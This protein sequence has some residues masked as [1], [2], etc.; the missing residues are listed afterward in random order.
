MQRRTVLL[1]AALAVGLTAYAYLFER[2]QPFWN[3][4]VGQTFPRLELTDIDA[5]ELRVPPAF[6]GAP[7]VRET[8]RL[9]RKREGEEQGWWLEGPP[10]PAHLPRVESI[11]FALVELQTIADVPP[12]DAATAF[13][14]G[15]PEIEVLFRANRS[16]A[17]RVEIGRD[18]PELD[19]LYARID[20][21]KLI[22]ARR[23]V[24]SGLH[25]SLGELRS[26][27]LLPVPRAE[28][29]RLEVAGDE[30][31][32]KEIRREGSSP[33][34][35]FASPEPALADQK[36]FHELL[37]E[38]N[39]WRIEAFVRDEE[40][41]LAAVGLAT[42]RL[43]VALSSAGGRRFVVLVGSE[44]P[45]S[46]PKSKKL[47]YVKWEG[48]PHVMTAA[49]SV[50]AILERSAENFYTPFVLPLSPEEITEVRVAPGDDLGG[51]A[52]SLRRKAPLAGD[53][54]NTKAATPSA[55]PPPGWEARFPSP[56]GTEAVLDADAD[57]VRHFL[58]DLTHIAIQRYVSRPSE[59]VLP[60]V[61]GPVAA[62]IEV[63]LGS[64]TI[65]RLTVA[66][67]SDD[68]EAKK[69]AAQVLLDGEP[70]LFQVVTPLFPDLLGGG[71]RWRSGRISS[72]DPETLLAIEI[73]SPDRAAAANTD[74]GA[75][76]VWNLGRPSDTW[77]LA[78]SGDFRLKPDQGIDDALVRRLVRALSR[79]EFRVQEWRP[80]ETA[81][82]TREVA[83]GA[84]RVRLRFDPAPSNG[85][86]GFEY[87]YLGAPLQIDGAT[88]GYWARVD[89]LELRA[90]LF[91][92][93]PSLSKEILG[94]VEHL[95]AV[96]ERM[97]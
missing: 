4:A 95:E 30:R 3:P 86:A 32:R 18:H 79:E 75:L 51:G 72:L 35:R 45:A 46:D 70:F 12:S 78:S 33:A 21:Q 92:L 64:G 10:F 39:A 20:G 44:V 68:A 55:T 53:E 83:P 80:E 2:E 82:E 97:R 8:I 85:R 74:G 69:G 47:V 66:R 16:G 54:G 1:L 38:L 41:D 50:V 13:D 94:L 27:A 26:R 6:P 36:L 29:V 22:L 58:D 42:P 89:T 87:L 19:L 49:A 23:E 11:C 25:A 24:R 34:W 67:P 14:P 7:G 88:L 65:R 52:F 43:S 57:H 17:H 77:Q 31:W 84:Y 28:A 96:T 61:K 48:R 81:L 91:L 5:I 62:R 9:S 90:L 63:V 71:A 60:D 37:D 40:G 93:E 76:R 56:G 73:A 59:A 15:G